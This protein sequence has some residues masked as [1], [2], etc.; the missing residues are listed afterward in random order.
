MKVLSNRAIRA[1]ADT[2]K[3]QAVLAV[4]RALDMGEVDALTDL[5]QAYSIKVM[6][7]A[8][9]IDNDNRLNLLVYGSMVFNSNGPDNELQRAA[10]AEGEKINVVDWIMARCERD[11]LA[12]GGF[13][14]QI[15][16]FS[17][18]GS[19]T[20]TEATR[21]VRM[22]LSAGVDSTISG[23]G[24]TLL[25]LARDPGQWRQ[26]SAEPALARW[27][28]EESIRRDPPFHTYYRTTTRDAEI[29]GVTIPEGRK[30]MVSLGA[31]GRDPRQWEKPDDF[32]LGR[33]PTGHLAFG[34][35]VHTCAG[36]AIARMQADALLGTIAEKVRSI[37]LIG[38]AHYTPNNTILGLDS[39][40][41][42]LLP[43]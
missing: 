40:P 29:S 33:R 5:C 8:L 37:E 25:A 32:D 7:D 13:G 43:H 21:L 16:R 24:Y 11:A 6:S 42:R 15:Y 9:G 41:L 38:E 31:A 27:A 17:D 2:F 36:L 12:P 14:E 23:L 18:D 30:V 3:E 35:G 4:D 1:L 28:F 19:L 20:N 39:L 34:R 22:F 10:F 26:L